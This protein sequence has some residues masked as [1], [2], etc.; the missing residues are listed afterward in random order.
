MPKAPRKADCT[1][2][3]E[4]IREVR[5]IMRENIEP[6]SQLSDGEA[7]SRIYR[8]VDND[9]INKAVTEDEAPPDP[10]N[11]QPRAGYY[12]AG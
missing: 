1:E 9:R 4:A 2:A 8:E 12:P 10:K 6:G 3:M 7:L 5:E 11:H